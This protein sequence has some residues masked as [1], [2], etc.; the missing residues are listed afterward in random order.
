MGEV[1]NLVTWLGAAPTNVDVFY[2]GP[3]CLNLVL[4]LWRG[5]VPVL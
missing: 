3:R 5:S 2:L 4:N 1:E